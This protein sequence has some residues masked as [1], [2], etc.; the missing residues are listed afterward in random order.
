MSVMATLCFKVF[1]NFTQPFTNELWGL[2]IASYLFYALIFYLI[3]WTNNTL[4]KTR[5][6]LISLGQSLSFFGTALIQQESEYKPSC[7]GEVLLSVVW[8][9]FSIL[10]LATYTAN[11][12]NAI[13]R[14]RLPPFIK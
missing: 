3:S 6:R 4:K 11:L 2:C 7:F 8:R 1:L 10:I 12:V 13:F 14:Q 5:E 9:I